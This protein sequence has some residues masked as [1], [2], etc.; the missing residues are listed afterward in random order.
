LQDVKSI[1]HS[2]QVWVF[3]QIITITSMSLYPQPKVF[4]NQPDRS[5]A[6]SSHS[7]YTMS[8]PK[9]WGVEYKTIWK[10]LGLF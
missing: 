3:L 1:S 5:V 10:Q 9:G 7:S 6:G 4:T 2:L 8:K